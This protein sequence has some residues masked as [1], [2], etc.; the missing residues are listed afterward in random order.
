MRL[1]LRG[2]GASGFSSAYADRLRHHSFSRRRRDVQVAEQGQSHAEHASEL[3][4]LEYE[5]I[6]KLVLHVMQGRP[7]LVRA[8]TREGRTWRSWFSCSLTTS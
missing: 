1:R 8:T 4:S 5:T 3:N 6:C 7:R 2:G